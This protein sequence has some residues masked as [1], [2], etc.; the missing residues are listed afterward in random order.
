M[1]KIINIKYNL[2]RLKCHL[3]IRKY[4]FSKKF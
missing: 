4:I 1:R 2:N 3:Y